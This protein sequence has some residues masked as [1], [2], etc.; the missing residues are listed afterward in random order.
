MIR[1]PILRGFH[2]DP[3]IVR[4]GDDF[5]VATSTFEWQPGVRVY[6]SRDLAHWEALGGILDSLDLSGVPDSGGVWA[7]DLTHH[8]GR[9]H[10]VYSVVD[11]YAYGTFDVSNYLVTAPAIGGPWSAPERLPGRGFD[12]S[13]FHDQETGRSWLLNMAYDS[14]PGRGFSGIEIQPLDGGKP[15]D[16]PRLIFE[17]TENG[18]TEGPRLLRSRGWYYLMTAE[19]GTGYEHGVTVARSRSLLGPYQPDPAGPMLTARHDPDLVLQKAGHGC[20]VETQSGE[21]YMTYLAARPYSRRGRCVLGRETAI[22]RV[23]WSADDWPR[24]PNGVP[25]RT[26]PAPS[27]P[28]HPFPAASGGAIG[29]DWSTLRRRANPCWITE[30]DGWLRITGGQ[31]PARAALPQPR[32]PACDGLAGPAGDRRRVHPWRHPLHGRDHPVLQHPQLA[33]PRDH[34]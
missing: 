12:P 14:R 26:V 25:A 31:V 1:N 18:V 7:P 20:L 17:G 9:F 27:L 16:L 10:L 24:V 3:C 4:V 19:G 5:Y 33:L 13:L 32:R 23:E 34:G 15:A 22:A 8:D 6:H 2:P 28:P 30:E 21:W 11:N 29:G